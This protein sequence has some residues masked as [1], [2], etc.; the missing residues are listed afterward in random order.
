MDRLQDT[1]RKDGGGKEQAK[2]PTED[3]RIHRV[4]SGSEL[5]IYLPAGDYTLKDVFEALLQAQGVNDRETR[6]IIQSLH[7]IRD[8]HL[9]LGEW[10]QL[11]NHLNDILMA[12]GDLSTMVTAMSLEG[13][14]IKNPRRRRV[15]LN[16]KW[17]SVKTWTNKLLDWAK[18]IQYI[19]PIPF[20]ISEAGNLSGP[21]WARDINIARNDVN[22]L[23]AN[24]VS[25]EPLLVEE[26]FSIFSNLILTTMSEADGNLRTTAGILNEKSEIVLGSLPDVN[27]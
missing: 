2:D 16:I 9:Q 5:R 21:A 27:I 20:S 19:H 12:L 7:E 13:D 10:K 25:F 26:K 14:S 23:L 4:K 1:S 17:S 22:V 6:K 8:I 11:H 15:E 24:D 3:R 18:E